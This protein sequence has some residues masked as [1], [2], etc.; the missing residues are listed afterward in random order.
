ML[1]DLTVSTKENKISGSGH[2]DT[3]VQ[4]LNNIFRPSRHTHRKESKEEKS[5]G[6]IITKNSGR[7]I[8]S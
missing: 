4:I 6:L 5:A 2:F 7:Y 3:R 1:P 8:V